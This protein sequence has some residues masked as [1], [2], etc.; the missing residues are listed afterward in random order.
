MSA[1]SDLLQ[2]IAESWSSFDDKVSSLSDLQLTAAGAD[3]WSAK[4]H[5]AHLSAWE[6]SLIALLAGRDRGAAIGLGRDEADTPGH[7]V[8]AINALIQ[9]RSRDRSL[10]DVLAAFRE[11]HQRCVAAVEALSDEDLARPYSHFQPND[12]GNTHP[13]IGWI[14]GNT[15]EHY[16]EHA[17]W[18]AQL[19]AKQ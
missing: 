12:P 8:D 7:D 6:E 4:D 2:R 16:D 1:K 19:L 14:V 17:G 5:V 9:R 10:G 3:G 18:I 13:V 15:Y 11:T